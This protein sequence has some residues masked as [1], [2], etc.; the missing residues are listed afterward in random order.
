MNVRSF[1]RKEKTLS[2]P[3]SAPPPGLEA[4]D[5]ALRNGPFHVALQL[6]ISN[7][8]LTLDRLEVRLKQRQH[9]IGRSTLSY[10][11][12]G[13]RRPERPASL[14]A[15]ATLEEILGLPDAALSS[16]LGA[17]KPRGRWIG[18]QGQELDWGELWG[19]TETVRGLAAI[20]RRRAF[21]RS[22]DVAITETLTHNRQRQV[23]ALESQVLTRARRDK[24]DRAQFVFEF[25]PGTDVSKVDVVNMEGCRIGRRRE[26]A[27]DRFI[28]FE[29]LF[30]RSLPEGDTHFYTL[31]LDLSEAYIEGAPP[32]PATAAG[33]TFRRPVASY[34]L[35]LRF[36]QEALPVRCYQSRSARI[37]RMGQ[38]AGDL[39]ISP[40]GTTHLAVQNASPGA[41]L[42]HWEWE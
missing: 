27:E 1:G 8:G 38:D 40:Q 35:R 30:D 5:E 20:D 19:N 3:P 6:A 13:Q 17:R 39:L 10:W 25:D 21:E 32:V 37:G 16:L 29:A 34:I 9:E 41:Y 15:L 18:Y 28:A 12:K 14:R 24:A 11:Q 33:R 42:T 2:T 36:D 22:Q 31:A 4:L 7:S 23:V 26:I